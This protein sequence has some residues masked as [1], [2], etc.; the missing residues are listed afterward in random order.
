MKRLS[1]S[2]Q[3]ARVTSI[4]DAAVGRARDVISKTRLDCSNKEN[5]EDDCHYPANAIPRSLF[6][7]VGARKQ[8]YRRQ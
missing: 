3:I 5:S 4:R 2:E 8:V 7:T 6:Q 1:S